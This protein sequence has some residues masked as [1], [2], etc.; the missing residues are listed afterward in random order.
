MVNQFA[1]GG[2]VASRPTKK[3]V[4]RAAIWPERGGKMPS[5]FLYLEIRIN[6]IQPMRTYQPY[7]HLHETSTNDYEVQALIAIPNG[8]RFEEVHEVTSHSIDG[9]RLFLIELMED[10][11]TQYDGT[12]EVSFTISESNTTTK[13]LVDVGTFSEGDTIFDSLGH[14]A[15]E[16]G[17]A[18]NDTPPE[19][20][21]LSG[22]TKKG[23]TSSTQVIRDPI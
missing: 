14:F 17:D 6:S 23:V 9:E 12:F 3:Q 15:A 19:D 1:F 16:V 13:I 8:M 4:V 21:N 5:L 11:N 20:R 10:S 7:L 2:L 22:G 18:T